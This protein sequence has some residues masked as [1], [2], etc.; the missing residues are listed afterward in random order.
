MAAEYSESRDIVT[1]WK[2]HELSTQMNDKV[3]FSRILVFVVLCCGGII[4]VPVQF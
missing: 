4:G 3:K 2:W 1:H